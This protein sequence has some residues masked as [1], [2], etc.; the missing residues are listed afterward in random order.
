MKKIIEFIEALKPDT[1]SSQAKLRAREMDKRMNKLLKQDR[2]T[3]KKG[4]A[5]RDK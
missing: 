2:E 5:A 3:F 1:G 4:L